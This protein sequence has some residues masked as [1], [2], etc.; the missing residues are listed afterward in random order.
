MGYISPRTFTCVKNRRYFHASKSPRGNVTHFL[1][2]PRGVAFFSREFLTHYKKRPKKQPYALGELPSIEL[3]GMER[4]G[5][6]A[7]DGE[8][9]VTK[10]HEE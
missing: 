2:T 8:T 7:R 5:D 3:I 6:G 9:D 4:Q 10:V 1:T